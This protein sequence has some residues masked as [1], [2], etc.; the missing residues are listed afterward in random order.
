MCNFPHDKRTLL[1]LLAFLAANNQII[2]RK[3]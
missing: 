1:S 2:T 3:T